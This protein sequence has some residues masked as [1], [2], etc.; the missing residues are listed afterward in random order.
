LFDF[1]TLDAA[2]RIGAFYTPYNGLQKKELTPISVVRIKGQTPIKTDLVDDGFWRTKWNVEPLS[3]CDYRGTIYDGRSFGQDGF[4]IR[5]FSSVAFDSEQS[6]M[7]YD[8]ILEGGTSNTEIYTLISQGTGFLT[9]NIP[10]GFSN[11][12][13]VDVSINGEPALQ[14]SV[15][16][17]AM[18]PNTIVFNSGFEPEAGLIIQVITSFFGE[19]FTAAPRG[20]SDIIV[21]GNEFL[22]PHFAEDHPEELVKVSAYSSLSMDVYYAG[23]VGCPNIISDRL[24]GDGITDTFELLQ[25]PH[26]KFAIWVYIDGIFKRLG[27]DFNVNWYD[28]SITFTTMPALGS[29][30]KITTFSAGGQLIAETH[31]FVSDGAIPTFQLATQTIQQNVYVLQ[32]G[33]FVGFTIDLNNEITFN[34]LP[35]LDAQIN[36]I[37]FTPTILEHQ[38]AI[39]VDTFTL[40]TNPPATQVQV[41]VNGTNVAFTLSGQVVTISSVA[42]NDPVS[43]IVYSTPKPSFIQTDTF[44][45]TLNG[46]QT[47]TLSGVVETSRPIQNN[48]FVR[49][50]GLRLRPDVTWYSESF[51]GQTVWV[52]PET[53]DL[54]MHPIRVYVGNIE[55]FTGVDFTFDNLPV[56]SNIYFNTPL[57]SVERLS[58]VIQTGEREFEVIAGTPPK[59]KLNVNT[60]D[61]VS[62]SFFTYDSTYNMQTEVFN[63]NIEGRYLLSQAPFGKDYIWV[64]LNGKRITRLKD[65]TLEQNGTNTWLVLAPFYGKL[66]Y[67]GTH[68]DADLNLYGSINGL[69]DWDETQSDIINGGWDAIPLGWDGVYNGTD[70]VSTH[71]WDLVITN[72][73]QL[74]W[75]EKPW[76]SELAEL[77]DRIIV[78]TI[79]GP[80]V[81]QPFAYKMF[82]DK[83]ENFTLTRIA[84]AY[85]LYL[86]APLG[87]DDREILL[88]TNP[89]VPVNALPIPILPTPSPENPG[90]LFIEGERI[91]FWEYE[92]HID[93]TTGRPYIRIPYKEVTYSYGVEQLPR[94]LRKTKATTAVDYP[95][96]TL[97]MPAGALE[98][99]NPPFVAASSAD[100]DSYQMQ[101]ENASYTGDG[102]TTEFAMPIIPSW[103]TISTIRETIGS[104]TNIVDRSRYIIT[105]TAVEFTTPPAIGAEITITSVDPNEFN[106]ALSNTPE[107]IFLRSKVGTLD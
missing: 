74:W 72:T 24:V 99:F 3:G 104:I 97:V 41:L 37:V 85:K 87:L 50:N 63:Q 62:V 77:T 53:I 95:I 75:D 6:G 105:E 67:W 98:E 17:N 65:Y 91:E 106:L 68:P 10:G 93:G 57:P 28:N 39:G 20:P 60:G 70:V 34:T 78:T 7:F 25:V 82:K 27:V 30:I 86:R 96:G 89:E 12:N 13:F 102:I 103:A 55:K 59:V 52:L 83:Y 8:T 29:D 69:P 101:V 5:N 49:K 51:I 54:S 64:H 48:I 36:I 80:P 14:Q 73:S 42:A 94:F 92:Q 33:V 18:V 21:E 31:T 81:V 84:D 76:D 1:D 38:S 23:T 88:D 19:T 35:P 44:T 58:L 40:A 32:N 90:V 100:P 79:A 107:A 46:A 43:V 15:A 2:D 9:Y 11:P 4:D 16:Y 71:T 26:N 22:Q 66:S 56:A 47:F 61:I 45:A